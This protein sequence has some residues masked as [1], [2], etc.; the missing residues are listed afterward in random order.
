MRRTVLVLSLLTLMGAAPAYA[1]EL[2]YLIRSA[3]AEGSNEG[4]V[5][6]KMAV[7]WKKTTGS[8]SPLYTKITTIKT[9]SQP[10]CRRLNISLVQENVPT[11]SGDKVV[12]RQD[13]Q[14]NVCSDGTPPKESI[15]AWE[16][17]QAEQKKNSKSQ[18]K[19]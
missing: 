18:V 9:F 2:T 14:M 6:G 19:K 7:F 15:E 10:D 16:K 11:K 5:T 4:E 8:N 3:A 12:Y 1:E 13:Y 17:L